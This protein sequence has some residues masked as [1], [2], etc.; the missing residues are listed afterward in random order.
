MLGDRISLQGLLRADRR[1]RQQLGV[2]PKHLWQRLALGSC[3][4]GGQGCARAL[5]PRRGKQGIQQ[6]LQRVEQSGVSGLNQV[7]RHAQELQLAR[8]E[9]FDFGSLPLT[10]ATAKQLHYAV[11]GHGEGTPRHSL[12]GTPLAKEFAQRHTQGL[13]DPAQGLGSWLESAV[14]DARKIGT[15]NAGALAQLAL[16]H[17]PQVA[18]LDNAGSDAH[19]RP[20]FILFPPQS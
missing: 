14:L 19:A 1:G 10:P 15:G 5:C 3:R 4:D 16:A 12:A 11:A 2:R 9:D 7:S 13:G 17:V 18:R 6:H 20:P 8:R